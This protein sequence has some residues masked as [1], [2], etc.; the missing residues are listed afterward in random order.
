M[1]RVT[2]EVV[3]EEPLASLESIEVDN[4]WGP[5]E[6][7][8]S[9]GEDDPVL[10]QAL[11]SARSQEELEELHIVV[12]R[13]DDTLYVTVDADRQWMRRASVAFRVAAPSDLHVHVETS[14][15]DIAVYGERHSATLR[16]SSGA[17]E[18]EDIAGHLDIETS[19]GSVEVSGRLEDI[20]MITTSSGAIRVSLDEGAIEAESSSG[21]IHVDGTLT[22]TSSLVSRSGAIDVSGIDGRL[23]AETSSGRIRVRGRL[24]GGSSLVSRSGG[25]TVDGMDGNLAAETSSGGIRVR[26]RLTGPSVFTCSSGGVELD[27]SDDSNVVVHHGRK[28]E[29]FGDGSDG[30]VEIDTHGSVR[31]KRGTLARP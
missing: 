18:V 30:T 6:V 15:G 13:R 20:G 10:V 8:A 2:D 12:E 17:V 25:V 28:I 24:A 23:E 26:G 5:V 19:S 21:A 3:R 22:G 14:S 11:R 7:V 4:R 1:G 16:A 9:P 27:L 29:T 31:V